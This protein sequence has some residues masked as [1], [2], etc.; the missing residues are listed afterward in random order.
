V[1]DHYG[2]LFVL[3]SWIQQEPRG[4]LSQDKI[5]QQAQMGFDTTPNGDVYVFWGGKYPWID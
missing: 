1:Q 4:H 5:L 2:N 3:E